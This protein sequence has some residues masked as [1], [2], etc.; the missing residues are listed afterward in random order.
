MTTE[1]KETPP[2]QPTPQFYPQYYGPAE[3]EISLLD[4]WHVLVKRW[5]LIFIVSVLSMVMAIAYA[6][7]LPKT[8]QVE[9]HI[10]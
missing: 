3:D 1:K 6:L 5:R 9:V 2:Q 4:L 8:Y 7:S 10:L